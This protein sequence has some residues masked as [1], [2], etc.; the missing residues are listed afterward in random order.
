MSSSV[1]MLHCCDCIQGFHSYLLSGHR[2]YI[3]NIAIFHLFYTYL[4]GDF[5][6]CTYFFYTFLA[7]TTSMLA[8]YVVIPNFSDDN[9]ANEKCEND[10]L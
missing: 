8:N 4:K 1:A 10:N 6:N 9:L 7:E 2:T 5:L 3:V